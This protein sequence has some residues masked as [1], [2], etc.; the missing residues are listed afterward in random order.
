[1]NSTLRLLLLGLLLFA[2][3]DGEEAAEPA[4]PNPDA[5]VSVTP[6][7]GPVSADAA[8]V[9]AD[10]APVEV[11]AA[12]IEP[13]A[14]VARP[15]E[16]FGAISGA[17]GVLTAALIEGPDPA[18]MANHID[19]AADP[20]DDADAPQL[21][22]GGREIIADG[23]AGGSSILSEVF[24]YEVLERCEGAAL[25]KTETEVTYQDVE[26]KMTDLL[27]SIGGHKV[28]VSVTRAVGWPREDP[29]PAE[30]A[31]GLLED[32]LGDVLLSSARVAPE[33]AWTKQILHVL[34]YSSQHEEVLNAAYEGLDPAVKA[35]TLLLI[36]VT[37][38]D[39]GFI[40]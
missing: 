40:Y 19:F 29:Y 22:E 15:T 14:S 6:D 26:G 5:A 11:D 2:C 9:G 1:M 21:T 7:V 37:D 25:L 27:V 36:T 33:D 13:D 30:Q 16:G 24:S 12:P 20:Y 18:Y 38:G 10:A 32:K 34:A 31:Q 23:N 39:D 3:D 17:C 35:D 8:P 28:G 4:S